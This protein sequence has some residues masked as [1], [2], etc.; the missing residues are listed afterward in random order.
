[1]RSMALSKEA[2]KLEVFGDYLLAGKPADKWWKAK[3]ASTTA[4]TTWKD[5]RAGFVTEF[6][7]PQAAE[8]TKQEYEK[9]LS[10]MQITLAELGTRITVGGIETHA[11][12][13]FARK[14]LRI[15][16]LAGVEKS[17]SNIWTVRDHLPKAIQQQVP[18]APKDWE[19]LS[20][21]IEKIDKDKLADDAAEERENAAVRTDVANLKGRSAQRIV[22][23]SPTAQI[24]TQ[25][26]RTT[27]ADAQRI[28]APAFQ[29]S[30]EILNAEGKAKLAELLDKMKA[31]MPLLTT[32]ETD[33]ATYKARM[34]RWE[35]RGGAAGQVETTGVPLSP[36]M[37]WPGS[38]ECFKCG[39]LTIP[40]HNAAACTG[41]AIPTVESRFRR[42]CAKNLPR[43]T[44]INAMLG[45]WMDD[46]DG[47][48]EDFPN[49]SL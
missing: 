7:A 41:T 6:D 47:D 44:P 16:K 38:G 19:E 45:S 42:I 21:E 28:P 40:K 5:A 27:L 36:G 33:T 18:R 10:G 12:V 48:E 13:A 4:F 25:M 49:R 39:K 31:A 34:T 22:P 37:V 17:S 3:Q 2:D 20:K 30:A 46:N 15:A 14:L 24:R 26:N 9:E 1:M 35:R 43:P 32:S 23:Q 8:K 29:N 11:H